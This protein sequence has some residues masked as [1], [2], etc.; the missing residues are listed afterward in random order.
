VKVGDLV[1]VSYN[2]RPKPGEGYVSIVLEMDNGEFHPNGLQLVKVLENGQ[3]QWRPIG[4]IEVIN[5][6][7]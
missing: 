5:E 2:L 7:R 6:G 1:R 4:Y 3:E